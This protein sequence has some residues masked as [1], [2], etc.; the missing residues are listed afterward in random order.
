MNNNPIYERPFH[1]PVKQL[2]YEYLNNFLQGDFGDNR[3]GTFIDYKLEQ[4]DDLCRHIVAFANAQGGIMFIGVDEKNRIPIPG[5]PGI[6]I[7][8]KTCENLL[9]LIRDETTPHVCPEIG[10]IRLLDSE[11]KG[12]VCMRIHPS[13]EAPHRWKVKGGG[14][15]PFHRIGDESRRLDEG[16]IDDMKS[17][18]SDSVELKQSL[19]RVHIDYFKDIVKK[20]HSSLLSFKHFQIGP[21]FPVADFINKDYLLKI[22]KSHRNLRDIS[23]PLDMFLAGFGQINTIYNGIV[24]EKVVTGKSC[25]L[26]TATTSNVVFYSEIYKEDVYSQKYNE[27][28]IFPYQG[29]MR[30]GDLIEVMSYV[31]ELFVALCREYG[32]SGNVEYNIQLE[33][34]MNRRIYSDFA[35]SRDEYKCRAKDPSFRRQFDLFSE[36]SEDEILRPLIQDI[37]WAFDF[38]IDD[39]QAKNCFRKDKKYF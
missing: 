6:P 30:L 7:D 5:P 8:D 31:L 32:Y 23:L 29:T 16:Y 1:T 36:R 18:R 20:C 38:Q 35:D 19:A 25:K 24:L 26:L 22:L 27:D 28:I 10:I 3:E 4:P 13:P 14:A 17:R 21:M 15:V 2:N 9:A 39:E 34:A 33:N 12:I 37:A 11:K